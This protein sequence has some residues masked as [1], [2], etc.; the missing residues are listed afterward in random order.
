MVDS[1]RRLD[2]PRCDARSCRWA[3][4]VI[5]SERC[6]TRKLGP[7]WARGSEPRAMAAAVARTG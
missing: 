5:D 2:L 3:A 6:L 7:R 1:G 4:A